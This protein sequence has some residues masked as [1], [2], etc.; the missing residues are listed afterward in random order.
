[1][2][3]G[4]SLSKQALNCFIG[5]P[6]FPY[7]RLLGEDLASGIAIAFRSVCLHSVSNN[8]P[9]RAERYFKEQHSAL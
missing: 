3:Y 6:P 7:I 8:F 9:N 4:Q 1:M 5:L 2:A